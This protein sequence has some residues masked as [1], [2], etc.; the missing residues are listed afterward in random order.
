MNKD[1]EK[2]PQ[3]TQVVTASDFYQTKDSQGKGVVLGR[4]PRLTVLVRWAIA[5][6]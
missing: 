5:A 2:E 4:T 3:P 1:S 6:P